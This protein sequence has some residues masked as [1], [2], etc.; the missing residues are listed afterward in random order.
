MYCNQLHTGYRLGPNGYFYNVYPNNA[1]NFKSWGNATKACHRKGGRLA[2][3]DTEAL[4]EFIKKEW[5]SGSKNIWIG[6][7]VQNGSWQW[8]NGNRWS[9]ERWAWEN[10]STEDGVCAVFYRVGQNSGKWADVVCDRRQKYLCEFDSEKRCT[11]Q[12]ARVNELMLP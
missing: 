9:Y 10:P 4:N 12:H 1:A 5:S 11:I 2:A 3:L 6:G 8:I 7:F